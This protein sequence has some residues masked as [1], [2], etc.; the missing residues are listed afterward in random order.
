[1]ACCEC[2]PILLFWGILMMLWACAAVASAVTATLT[3]IEASP[4]AAIADKFVV[5]KEIHIFSMKVSL[6]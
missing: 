3:Q 1:M 4:N 6:T 5:T 2:P